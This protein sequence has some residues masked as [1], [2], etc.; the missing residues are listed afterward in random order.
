MSI[1]SGSVLAKGPVGEPR[2]AYGAFRDF[3]LTHRV[4][5]E[6][7]IRTR[8]TQTNVIQRTSCLLPA[9]ATV[10]ERGGRRPLALV[11][12]GCSAHCM[13]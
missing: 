3:C 9:F 11:E 8:L 5:V 12:I 4:E 1:S 6:G 13:P 7:L 2:A 10:F